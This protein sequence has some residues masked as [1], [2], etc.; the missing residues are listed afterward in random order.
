MP[1]ELITI[2]IL[3]AIGGAIGSFALYKIAPRT[4]TNLLTEIHQQK[5]RVLLEDIKKQNQA[6]LVD[7][8]A[9]H[10][11]KLEE[12]KKEYQKELES[13]KTGLQTVTRYSE[14]QFKLYNELWVSLFELKNEAQELWE[15]ANNRNLTK[16]V[17]QLIE[18][19][20]KIEQNILLINEQHYQTLMDLIA[21]FEKFKIGKVELIRYRNRNREN[22]IDT[23]GREEL[24]FIDFNEQVKD[25]Y[26]NLVDTLAKEFKRT[27]REPN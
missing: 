11:L 14:Y 2:P 16:F 23:I 17:K 5:N 20:K 26:I 8:Q 24:E 18:T 10:T 1:T 9:N 7:I 21:T 6:I 22:Y 4:I 13:Y 27:L 19:K 15:R 12:L 3:S 25:E